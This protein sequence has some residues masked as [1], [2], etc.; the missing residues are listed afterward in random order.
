MQACVLGL[1]PPITFEIVVASLGF[2]FSEVR[3]QNEFVQVDFRVK[4]D[5]MAAPHGL[6][7]PSE[8]TGCHECWQCCIVLYYSV[9]LLSAICQSYVPPSVRESSP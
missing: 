2:N 8:E 9:V 6:S 4:A 1:C 7:A 5:L 3:P